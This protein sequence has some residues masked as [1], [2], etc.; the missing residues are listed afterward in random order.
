MKYYLFIILFTMSLMQAQHQHGGHGKQIPKGCEIYGTVVDSITGRAIEYASISI[1][2]GD[3]TI[4][5]GGVTNSKGEFEIKEI[6]PGT[7][8]VKIEF[9]GFSP[10]LMSDIKLSYRESRVKEIG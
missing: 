7:Y 9:M 6:N 3:G 1:I 10:V 5:T 4:E 8:N 2:T